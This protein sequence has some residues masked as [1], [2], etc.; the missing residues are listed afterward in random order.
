M[1]NTYG[2]N[3]VDA[4]QSCD[5]LG[6]AIVRLLAEFRPRSV[7]DIG[8]GNGTL[9]R[10]LIDAGY[11]VAG[12]EP[13]EQGFEIARSH[14]GE[15]MLLNMGV[16][17]S[18]EA[19]LAHF[20][21]RFD[22]VVSTEVVEHLYAPERLAAFAGA[23]LQ[24]GGRAVI[25]TPYHGLLKNIAIAAAGMWDSHHNP[26]WT[27][28]H[29]KFWSRKTLRSLFQSAGFREVRFLGVGRLPYLWKSMVIVFQKD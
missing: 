22:C 25:S 18:P 11:E 1:S 10:L 24:Q 5:Y 19:L 6:T 12:V 29:I 13:D 17:D 9:C 3:N 28:G 4:P 16:E 2:W 27:G 15:A 21:S 14:C 20:P 23:C 26:L 8:A 7:L